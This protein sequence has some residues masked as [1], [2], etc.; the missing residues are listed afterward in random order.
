[1]LS[2]GI[3]LHQVRAVSA[4]RSSFILSRQR[5]TSYAIPPILAGQDVVVAAETGG[6]KTL[7]F[8][9][10]VVEQLSRNSL[11]LSEMRLPI[12]L[13]LTTSQ[14]LV[15]QLM[16]VLTQVEPELAQLAVIL[17]S[18]RQSIGHSDKRACPLVFATPGALLRATKPKDFAFTQMVVVDE[19]DM[20][21]SGGFEKDTKQILATIR[22]Q[23]LLKSELN[24]CGDTDA[25]PREFRGEDVATKHTQTIFSAISSSPCTMVNALCATTSTINFRRLYSPLLRAFTGRC[26]SDMGKLKKSGGEKTLVF[27]NSIASA[28]ALF[29][30]LQNDKGMVNCALFHKEREA[31]ILPRSCSRNFHAL[32]ATLGNSNVLLYVLNLAYRHGFQAMIQSCN[33][34]TI[35]QGDRSQQF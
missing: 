20:L 15:R 8:L 11:P 18:S 17:S 22:N 14:E 21:L 13:V 4:I 7:A 32:Q 19:A 10:P 34:D 9:L 26:Q 16:T 6:G 30:F 2:L 23:P 24:R 27:T 29:D 1:M 25:K 3:Y 31:W 5:H 33:Q 28:D 35:Q 12:A